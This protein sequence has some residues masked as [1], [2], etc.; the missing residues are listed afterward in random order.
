MF[1]CQS[2]FFAGLLFFYLGMYVC[3]YVLVY[4]FTD[5][6]TVTLH[7]LQRYEEYTLR[8]E[9]LSPSI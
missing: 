4:F 5:N 3:M 2:P 7:R 9:H 8:F 6:I 1:K